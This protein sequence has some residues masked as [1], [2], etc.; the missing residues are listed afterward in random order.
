MWQ[1]MK[2]FKNT[3]FQLMSFCEVTFQLNF[4][5]KMAL[6]NNSRWHLI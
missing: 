1:K 5:G 2:I 3:L 6:K 4:F